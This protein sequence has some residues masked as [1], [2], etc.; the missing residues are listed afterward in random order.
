MIAAVLLALTFHTEG[1]NDFMR[2]PAWMQPMSL[3]AAETFGT[4]EHMAQ[5]SHRIT[6]KTIA[7]VIAAPAAFYERAYYVSE[8]AS[9]VW[10][11]T[12][13]GPLEPSADSFTNGLNCGQFYIP[14]GTNDAPLTVTNTLRFVEYDNVRNVF[15]GGMMPLVDNREGGRLP[16]H[17]PSWDSS[18]R[19]VFWSFSEMP[20]VKPF[21]N[22]ISWNSAERFGARNPC[23]WFIPLAAPAVTGDE[24]LLHMTAFNATPEH[25]TVTRQFL[26]EITFPSILSQ[27]AGDLNLLDPKSSYSFYTNALTDIIADAFTFNHGSVYSDSTF[28]TRRLVPDEFIDVDADAQRENIGNFS[29]KLYE[30]KWEPWNELSKDYL[31]ENFFGYDTLYADFDRVE[32]AMP[33]KRGRIKAKYPTNFG[34]PMVLRTFEFALTNAPENADIVVYE[35]GSAASWVD[36]ESSNYWESAEGTYI[37][38]AGW[39]DGEPNEISM[40]AYKISIVTNSE[41]HRV[42][43]IAG[44]CR[45]AAV[46]NRTYEI[47]QKKSAAY[48]YTNYVVTGHGFLTNREAIVNAKV[49]VKPTPGG[50]SVEIEYAFCDGDTL[51]MPNLKGKD[52][53]FTIETNAIPLGADAKFDFFHFD[54]SYLSVNEFQVFATE[55]SELSGSGMIAI[56]NFPDLRIPEGELCETRFLLRVRDRKPYARFVP[57][58]HSEFDVPVSGLEIVAETNL[59]VSVNVSAIIGGT[60]QYSVSDKLDKNTASRLYAFAGPSE[61]CYQTGRVKSSESYSAGGAI[62]E[63]VYNYPRD[64]GDDVWPAL[65][66]ELTEAETERQFFRQQREY[67]TFP[68]LTSARDWAWLDQIVSSRENTRGKCQGLVQAI[69]GGDPAEPLSIMNVRDAMIKGADLHGTGYTMP[70]NVRLFSVPSDLGTYYLLRDGTGVHLYA[71]PNR[72][73]EVDEIQVTYIIGGMGARPQLVG[74]IPMSDQC[75]SPEYTKPPACANGKTSTIITTDWKWKALGIED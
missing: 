61:S 31:Y 70:G 51:A 23:Y 13:Y 32:Y 65:G 2:V 38:S 46:M 10:D 72:G 73:V 18:Y 60:Y 55:A 36:V 59:S 4:P 69:V 56:T 29:V 75:V 49:T 21:D 45:A 33:S 7:A 12:E 48:N 30:G 5:A 16:L 68:K 22:A 20:D 67:R 43:D 66:F 54:G 19:K 25:D 26:E 34:E 14:H 17:R 3:T 9:N 58:G 52:M 64:R 57:L 1:L 63:Y 53:E 41:T 15:A 11:T 35:G 44:A 74:I 24:G 39:I 71:D 6:K 40:T 50:D 8:G 37:A 27:Q 62:L 28:S 42:S 47:A